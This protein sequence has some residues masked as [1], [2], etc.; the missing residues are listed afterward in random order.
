M[1][2]N[3]FGKIDYKKMDRDAQEILD[4]LKLP[5]R[6]DE[7]VADL[8]VAKR[9]MVEIGKALSKNAKIIVLD[10]PTAVL[11]ESELEGL[12]DLV[13][14][15][16][17]QG[18]AF[19]YISHRLKEVF[20][21]C[22]KV[23]ILKDGRLVESGPVEDYDTDKLVA[24]MVGREMKDVYPKRESKIGETVLKVEGLTRKGVLDNVSLELHKGEILGLA[25]LAGAGR[26]ETL[27]GHHRGGSPSTPAKLSTSG[28]RCTSRTSGPR[29]MPAWA[30]YR[31]NARSPACS[32]GRT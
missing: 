4:R 16:S 18:I 19:I 7:L 25:G 1:P 9:Q 20:A 21:L 10:E 27:R 15:L 13:R 8:S 26:S 22:N 29:W 23:T 24:K 6:P 31:R 14:T 32:C 5:V 28:K 11:A 17:K 30:S 2:V 12:F 3:K